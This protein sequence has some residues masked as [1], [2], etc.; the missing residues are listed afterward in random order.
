MTKQ[1]IERIEKLIKENPYDDF[2][3]D[4]NNELLFEEVVEM[5]NKGGY[6]LKLIKKG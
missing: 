5:V 2:W 3:V 1:D 6:D 4:D